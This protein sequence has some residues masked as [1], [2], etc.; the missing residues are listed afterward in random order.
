MLEKKEKTHYKIVC[1]G[2]EEKV[3]GLHLFGRGSDEILQ[4]FGVAIK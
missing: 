4:G 3:V 2:K 1:Y